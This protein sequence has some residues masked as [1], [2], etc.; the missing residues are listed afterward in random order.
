MCDFHLLSWFWIL[1]VY[2][3]QFKKKVTLLYVYNE[4]TSEPT[5][6]RYASVVRKALKVLICYLTNTHCGNPMSHGTRQSD[7]PFLS[8]HSPACPC[9][10][11]PQWQ[12]CARLH[13]ATSFSGSIVKDVVYVPPLPNDLKKLRQHII[14]AVATINK[15]M[16]ERVW[17][18]MD[19]HI[20]LMCDTGFP[21][22]VSVR[23]HQNL[24]SFPNYWCISCDC[25]LTGYFIM[26]MWKCYLLF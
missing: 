13:R 11:L 19:H 14:A 20:R 5:I 26:I 10:W 22:W 21:H 3:G 8:R 16:L 4:V 18:E 15:D 9:L 24:A 12:C 7:S 23:E 6:T 25:R 17:T 2:T 1:Y